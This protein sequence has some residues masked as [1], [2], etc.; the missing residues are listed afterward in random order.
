VTIDLDPRYPPVNIAAI[1][2]YVILNEHKLI[3]KTRFHGHRARRDMILPLSKPLIGSD[4]RDVSEITVPN[5][6]N[7]I[8]SILG[9]N[10]DPELWGAD[11]HEWKPDRWLSPP[12]KDVVEAHLP[13]IYS[14]LYVFNV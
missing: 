4:G 12:P 14:H 3:S 6:T 9:S 1:R 10:T 13:G 7:I 11:A 8:I 5:G 2:T